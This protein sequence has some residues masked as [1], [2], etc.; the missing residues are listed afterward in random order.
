MKNLVIATFAFVSVC[1]LAQA[2]N[3]QQEYYSYLEK[4]VEFSSSSQGS[5][6]NEIVIR[7]RG[8]IVFPKTSYGT[9]ACELM[10]VLRDGIVETYA[11]NFIQSYT[12][13]VNTA[14][15]R[16]RYSKI[17]KNVSPITNWANP[18]HFEDIDKT[19]DNEL[20]L[21]LG[22]FG[23]VRESIQLNF[24]NS[25]RVSSFNSNVPGFSTTKC[26]F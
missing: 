5:S 17:N 20:T 6:T 21:T 11:S 26:M 4:A 25:G 3:G 24:D 15:N 12:V 14:S 19:G 9:N 18:N 22:N 10:I 8:N 1:S 13:S 16:L 7:L 2:S 23:V